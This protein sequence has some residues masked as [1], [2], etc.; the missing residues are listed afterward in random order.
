MPAASVTFRKIL[1]PIDFSTCSKKGLVYAKNLA[2]EFDST[3]VLLH[4][5]HLHYYV[6]NDEY[7]RYDFSLVMEQ[8][9]KSAVKQMRDLINNTD[10]EGVTSRIQR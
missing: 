6:T 7:A 10:W 8:V 5:V 9:E 1:V 3:L 4:A 2:R